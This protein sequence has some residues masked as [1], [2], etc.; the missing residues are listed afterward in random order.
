[1]AIF[2]ELVWLIT[3]YLITFVVSTLLIVYVLQVPLFITGQQKLIKEYY[4]DNILSSTILDIFLIFFYLL[5]AQAVIYVLN[6]NRMVTRMLL[7]AVVTLCIS[8]AFYLLFKSKPL[9]KKSFFSR[10]FYAAGFYA[11]IYDIVLIT[12]TY[13][14]L[15]FTLMKTKKRVS[16][17]LK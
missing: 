12:T 6:V 15:M 10:W 5:L 17:W 11:V 8:G 1:M 2:K 4:Y 16:E 9:D 7:V 13:A 14:I 3:S